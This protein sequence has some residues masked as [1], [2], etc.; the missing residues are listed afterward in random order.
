MPCIYGWIENTCT[1]MSRGRRASFQRHVFLSSHIPISHLH[2]HPPST[3]NIMADEQ[4]TRFDTRILPSVPDFPRHS[5]HLLRP[6]FDGDPLLNRRIQKHLWDDCVGL[7]HVD[8]AII[9]AV[10]QHM[11][12]VAH[13]NPPIRPPNVPH[14]TIEQQ[15]EDTTTY[16]SI[17]DRIL[18][19]PVDQLKLLG[20]L[21]SVAL[22]D[23]RS[24]G[25]LKPKS[26]FGSLSG[27]PGFS[28]NPTTPSEDPLV[29]YHPLFTSLGVPMFPS[30][31]DAPSGT[32]DGTDPAPTAASRKR[33]STLQTESCLTRHLN[34][35][36]ITLKESALE[37]AHI[38]P[39]S[40][41]KLESE[42]ASPF[43]MMLGVCLGPTLRD[44]VF[45]LLNGSIHSTINSLALDSGLH[46]AYDAGLFHLAA[47][48]DV[49]DHFDPATCRQYDVCFRWWG[50]QKELGLWATRV[51]QSPEA[52]V[53]PLTNSTAVAG[54][55]LVHAH[56]GP[57]REIA[58]RDL[59]RIFTN[60]PAVNP[61][62]HP[63]LLEIH[64]MLWRMMA[65]AGMSSTKQATKRRYS[66][67]VSIDD[68]PELP[69]SGPRG[70][71]GPHKRRGTSRTGTD[72]RRGNDQS[73]EEATETAGNN[74]ASQ[75]H[76]SHVG[77]ASSSAASSNSYRSSPRS[78]PS[79]GHA[80][81]CKST[82]PAA[83]LPEMGSQPPGG[84][85][86]GH[87]EYMDFQLE[88]FSAWQKTCLDGMGEW[89]T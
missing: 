72:S 23:A 55:A 86:P 37:H 11:P 48:G 17:I 54:V 3:H 67:L 30:V 71:A 26:G 7:E 62:P 49:L 14:T 45:S 13:P 33:R 89:G 10:L 80:Y 28:G 36:P 15:P 73:P 53:R 77:Y 16:T 70:S 60:N 5:P 42:R 19:L 6:I 1:R 51:Y 34:A 59:Y 68:N 2:Q 74:V 40:V 29:I 87:L 22:T 58:D 63:L 27:S 24:W 32:P 25:G 35:C 75:Q 61:L 18:S 64:G 84:L 46:T 12:A 9:G 79:D 41:I 66:E 47:T 69:R 39:Y 78:K 56:G 57:F 44:T 38:L 52:Q 43:W 31:I 81:Q 20:N 21:F 76:T 82:S 50:T 83:S 4:Q 65:T 8:R 88:R 85:N